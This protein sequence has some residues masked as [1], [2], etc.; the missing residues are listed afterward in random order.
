[1]ISFKT[2]YYL[3]VKIAVAQKCHLKCLLHKEITCLRS[4][5]LKTCITHFNHLMSLCAEKKLIN[6]AELH[7]KLTYV[8]HTANCMTTKTNIKYT[9]C[10]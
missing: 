6:E 10:P 3:K 5:I 7:Y 4:A 8:L 1:M 2:V 9:L